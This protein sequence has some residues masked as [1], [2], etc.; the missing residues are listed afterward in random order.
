MVHTVLKRKVLVKRYGRFSSVGLLVASLFFY[1]SLTPSLIPRSSIHQ[2]VLSGLALAIGYGIGV[3]LVWLWRYVELP[4]PKKYRART[5]QVIRVCS[6]VLVIFPLVRATAWQNS[7]RRLM[8]LEDISG[9]HQLLLVL[10]AVAISLL[11]ISVVRLLWRASRYV[12]H[13]LSHVIPRR[14]A[15]VLGV[16]LV[17]FLVFLVVNNVFVS[18]YL[19][20]L[21]STYAEIDL[22]TGEVFEQPND[23]LRTG[24][25]SSLIAWDTLSVKGKNFTSTGPTQEEI[26]AFSG[27]EAMQPLRVYVGLRSAETVEERAE[28]ALAEL[29]RVGAFNRS[30]LVLVTP[31]GSGWID[32]GAVDTLEYLHNGDTAIAALQYSYLPSSITLFVYPELAQESSQI[33]F[34]NV[35]DYWTTLP[36]ETRPRLYVHGVSLGVLGSESSAQLYELIEDPIDGAVWAGPPFPSMI[37]N[38]VT[39][40][41]NSDSPVWLP[42]FDDGSLVRFTGRENEL[43]LPNASWGMMRIVYI[44]HPSDPVTFF[45]PDLW[46]KEPAWLEQ[47]GPDVS[48]SLRWFPV[49]TFFQVAFD[50]H[51]ATF[52]PPGY[53]HNFAPSSYIDAWVEVTQADVSAAD[54]QRLKELFTR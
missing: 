42:V 19:S 13:K 4:Q 45:S 10:L 5:L 29:R 44:Q 23:V 51:V 20:A 39:N 37:W 9:G 17:T 26:S 52:A 36:K 53:G 54:V 49:V 18:T 27:K 38:Q 34:E 43:D 15:N 24:S 7:I 25:P 47:R 8:G 14:V 31:T 22:L 16:V 40:A 28:L 11:L 35:Y 50:I 12:S 6:I 48:P 2:G 32:P 1:A 3:S 30:V 41:R 46:Y 33:M 21:D